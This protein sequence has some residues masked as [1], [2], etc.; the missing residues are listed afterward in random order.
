MKSQILMRGEA[1]WARLVRRHTAYG[2]AV[3][4]RDITYA[5]ARLTLFQDLGIT[6]KYG[7]I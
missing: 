4:L 1:E 3:I 7:I 5:G 6:I 2:I